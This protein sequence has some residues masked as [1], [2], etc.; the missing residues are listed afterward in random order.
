MQ[1][2]SLR[3]GCTPFTKKNTIKIL[4]DYDDSVLGPAPVNNLYLLSGD[5]IVVS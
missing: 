3:E 2:I 5:F 1:G 4:V